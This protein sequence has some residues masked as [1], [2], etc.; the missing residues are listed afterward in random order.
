MLMINTMKKETIISIDSQYIEIIHKNEEIVYWE[1][2][3]WLDDPDIVLSIA[4]AIYLAA[5]GD[6]DILKKLLT[7]VGK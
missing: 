6:I 2:Q 1:R 3:E 7:G 4:N 5:S